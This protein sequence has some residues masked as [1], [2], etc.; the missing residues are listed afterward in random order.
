M[1]NNH[2]EQFIKKPFG[3]NVALPKKTIAEVQKV[4]KQELENFTVN[5]FVN[6]LNENYELSPEEIVNDLRKAQGQIYTLG[7]VMRE[8]ATGRTFNMN[9]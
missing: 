6:F 4:A 3:F 9:F 2:M 7:Q 8:N 5:P 1:E